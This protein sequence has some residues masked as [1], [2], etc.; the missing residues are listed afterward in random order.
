MTAKAL[1]VAC[2]DSSPGGRAKGRCEYVQPSK[3]RKHLLLTAPIQRQQPTNLT[4]T[5]TGGAYQSARIV[6]QCD[7]RNLQ[8]SSYLN[9]TAAQAPRPHALFS[10]LSFLLREK[11]Q[12][13]R[14]HVRNGL[15]EPSRRKR[16]LLSCKAVSSF[17]TRKPSLRVGV[18][19]PGF[20]PDTPPEFWPRSRPS[21]D[22]DAFYS[23]RLS[24]VRAAGA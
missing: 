14:R 17:P 8:I 15:T 10:P 3:F 2:G 4:P 22:R 18:F 12:G 19:I 20:S 13:R 7:C 1:S 24:A 21:P 6:T 11:R 23:S 9:R 16:R 5:P